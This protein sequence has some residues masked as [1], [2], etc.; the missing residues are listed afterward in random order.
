MHA[1]VQRQSSHGC[2]QVPL[3]DTQPIEM[4]SRCRSLR[5]YNRSVV[6]IH[7]GTHGRGRVRW[8]YGGDTT[9]L[10]NRR[11]QRK[12]STSEVQSCTEYS[13]IQS[14]PVHAV[15]YAD[16]RTVLKELEKI[17]HSNPARQTLLKP[18]TWHRAAFS[19]PQALSPKHSSVF[20]A[21]AYSTALSASKKLAQKEPDHLTTKAATYH[22]TMTIKHITHAPAQPHMCPG[23]W[24]L[25]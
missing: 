2:L 25:S 15:G 3:R 22:E 11:A 8:W 5:Q 17:L 16:S 9:G 7:T 1:G 12:E 14:N 18:T 4:A 13:W 23:S 10:H 19:Q 21:V 6:H 20:H 24:G